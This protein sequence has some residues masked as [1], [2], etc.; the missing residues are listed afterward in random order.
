MFWNKTITLYNRYEDE[1]TGIITWYRHIIKNCFYKNTRKNVNSGG[2]QASADDNII[3]IPAQSDYI[4]PYEWPSLPDNLKGTK[5]TLQCGDLI[6]LG[7]V[8]DEIDEYTAGQRSSD[9]IAKYSALGSVSIN[10]VHI[11]TD[12]PNQH[13]FVRGE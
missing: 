10:E 12:L 3:R 11:N 4:S 8:A 1:Q 2:V 5:M 9:L 6:I 7:D 13:Y